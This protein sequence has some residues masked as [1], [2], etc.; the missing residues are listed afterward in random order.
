MQ[1]QVSWELI[2]HLYCRSAQDDGTLKT[3]TSLQIFQQYGM[4]SSHGIQ[5]LPEK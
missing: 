5:H 4:F 1:L 3:P 2:V